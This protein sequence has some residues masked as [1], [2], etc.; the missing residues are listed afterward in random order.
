[1]RPARDYTGLVRTPASLN[2]LLKERARIRGILDKRLKL[3]ASLPAEICKLMD[4]LASLDI[5]IPLH[6]I[7]V[8]PHKI[9]GKKPMGPR[10]FAKQGEF[11]RRVIECLKEAKGQRYTWEITMHVCRTAGIEVT[12]DNRVRVAKLFKKRLQHL[13]NQGL[14]RK[15]HRIGPGL[16]EEGIWSLVVDEEKSDAAGLMSG[17]AASN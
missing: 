10:L 11:T 2:Y 16:S 13:A 3:V 6:E 15:H 12:A 4:S 8:E 9:E 1:M 7:K 17:D 14:V 5:V